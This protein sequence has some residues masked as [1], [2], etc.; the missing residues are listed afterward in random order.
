MKKVNFKQPKYIL[1]LVIFLP[2][3][4]LGYT[5]SNFFGEDEEKK[6][7]V[8]DNINM[9]LPDAKNG[10][11]TDKMTEM[12]RRFS[13]DGAYT[14]IGALGNEKEELDSTQAGYKEHELNSIDAEN[15]KREAKQK[16][17][18][19]LERS[20]AESRKHI[21]AMPMTVAPPAVAAMAVVAVRVRMS[22]MTMP[23]TWRISSSAARK[24]RR[25]WNGHS[26]SAVLLMV[27]EVSVPLV[28]AVTAL[29][30]VA[31]KPKRSPRL[32]WYRRCRSR[33]RTSSI[34][35]VNRLRLM[36]R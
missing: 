34:L 15:A 33:M 11:M 22:W 20:L 13:E 2:L 28:V 4:F 1:P 26:A 18:E 35:S 23:V 27:R 29:V 30:A 21:N 25:C 10:E 14:A 17:L 24:G 6:G 16:E 12:T 3:V 8:T 19:D 32:S 5:L 9:T 31:R 7:V 36:N